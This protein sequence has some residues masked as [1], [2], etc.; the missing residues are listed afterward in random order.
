[1]SLSGHDFNLGQ[2]GSKEATMYSMHCDLVEQRALGEN[3]EESDKSL[4]IHYHFAPV[5]KRSGTKLEK[6]IPTPAFK[7]LFFASDFTAAV[8]S[9]EDY[10]IVAYCTYF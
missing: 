7:Y 9:F 10:V 5:E 1:M 4:L 8:E 6:L 3:H 2:P